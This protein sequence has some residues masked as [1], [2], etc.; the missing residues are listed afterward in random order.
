MKRVARARFETVNKFR[1]SAILIAPQSL[2][3]FILSARASRKRTTVSPVTQFA[4]QICGK[5][6]SIEF[7]MSRLRARLFALTG[8]KTDDFSPS[9]GKSGGE[10]MELRT[11]ARAP[12]LRGIINNLYQSLSRRRRR[13]SESRVS[14][15]GGTE[16]SMT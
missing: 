1:S 4:R 13:R 5:L 16:S 10:E 6:R 11:I 9:I 14:S 15:G 2:A 8:R 12:Y 3:R 7:P